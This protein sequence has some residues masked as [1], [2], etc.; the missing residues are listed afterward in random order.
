MFLEKTCHTRD[1][2][3]IAGPMGGFA[4]RILSGARKVLAGDVAGWVLEMLPTAVRNAGKGV[5]MATT[6]I[7][8]DAKGYKVLDTNTL[9]A[10]VKSIGF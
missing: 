1:V 7:D 8:R 10:A 4:T 3:E 2:M 9:E 5:D 6:G